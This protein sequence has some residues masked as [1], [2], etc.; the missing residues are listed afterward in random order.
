M[1]DGKTWEP[2]EVISLPTVLPPPQQLEVRRPGEDWTGLADSAQRRKLQNRL[3][4]RAWSKD[5]RS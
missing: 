2:T 3:H 4:Q 1:A 5:N